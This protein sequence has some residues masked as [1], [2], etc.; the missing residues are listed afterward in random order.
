M[1]F[2]IVVK[3]KIKKKKTF[4]SEGAEVDPS[5]TDSVMAGWDIL[6]GSVETMGVALG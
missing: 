1:S 5:P 2:I 3:A 4:V 6:G